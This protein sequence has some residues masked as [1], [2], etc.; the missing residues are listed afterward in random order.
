MN[1]TYIVVTIRG[2]D[3]NRI[4]GVFSD[5]KSAIAAKERMIADSGEISTEK[6]R[7]E[8]FIFDVVELD[9][10]SYGCQILM[11]SS[12]KEQGHTFRNH[13]YSSDQHT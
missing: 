6:S 9:K 5:E 7:G 2:W 8:E 13:L 10:S 1:K 11:S 12:S 3:G 4:L